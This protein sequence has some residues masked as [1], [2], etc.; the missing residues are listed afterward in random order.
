MKRRKRLGDMLVERD[1][2]SKFQ[3]SAALND[4]RRWGNR[5][6]TSLI[7]LGFI[8]EETLTEFLATQYGLPS[9]DLKKEAPDPEIFKGSFMENPSWTRAVSL[10][11]EATP[12]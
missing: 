7:R 12:Q 6:G 3:L 9:V 11:M 5:L 1:V 4:Q 2:I 8:H 10:G